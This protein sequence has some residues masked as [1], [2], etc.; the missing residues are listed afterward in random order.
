M[1]DVPE[2]NFISINSSSGKYIV[3]F[4]SSSLELLLALPDNVIFIDEAIIPV[5]AFEKF[6]PA[7]VIVIR[8]SEH[9]KSIDKIEK[10]L[11]KLRGAGV[12]RSHKLI[13]VGGGV[14]Q[15]IVSFLAQIYFRGIK[16]WFFPTTLLSQCD[17]CIGSKSSINVGEH[18][19][20]VGGF[21][22]PEKIFIDVAF[23]RSL[24]QVDI[25]SGIGELIKIFLIFDR[26]CFFDFMEEYDEIVS[27]RELDKYIFHALELKKK[28]IEIDEFDKKERLVMNYGH[29]F[30]HAFESISGY[31]IS[32]GIAVTAGIDCANF[33]GKS[34]YG[35]KLFDLTSEL[36]R[37]NFHAKDFSG[38]TGQ[39]VVRAMENDKKNAPGH[40]ALVIPGE[41][42]KISLI[43]TPDKEKLSLLIDSWVGS[44]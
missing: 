7:R 33:V 26:S 8:P 39:E 12:G 11:V 20:I 41:E 5:L 36:L 25:R 32:H 1:L 27:T 30:G 15:D 17:S 2:E 6:D 23:L 24:D 43:Q 19:N 37:K 34:L 28:I 16:W 10:Y 21:H 42:S 18:K 38:L 35:S 3:E 31:S 9:E 13:A 22:P 40:L 14:T 4:V 44:L 29:G